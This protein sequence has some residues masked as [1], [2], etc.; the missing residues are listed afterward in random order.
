MISVLAG[1]SSGVEETFEPGPTTIPQASLVEQPSETTPFA[2]DGQV[3]Y[4]ATNEPGA[5]DD[6]N[7]LYPTHRGGRDGPWRTIQH[8]AD[9]LRQGD[10]AHVREGV[11][12]EAGITFAN[13]GEP[14]APIALLNYEGETVVI[15]G[16]E[17]QETLPGI[18][19]VQGR[20]HYV[21]E[22]FTIRNMPWSGIATDEQT[23][24]PYHDITIRNCILYENGWSGIDLAAVDGFL[25]EDV[26]AYSNHFYGMNIAASADGSL[27]SSNGLV[28]NGS[29]HDHTGEEG[30]GLAIN[31]GHDIVVSDS[32]AYHNL[33]HGF[34]VS[35]WPKRGDVSHDIMFERNSSYDNGVSGFSINSNSH[36]VV[37]QNN[38]A[39][40][41]GAEW[42]GKGTATG[43][44]CYGGCWHVEW[45]NNVSVANTAAGFEVENQLGRNADDALLVFRN[46]VT[47]Q[48]GLPEWGDQRPGLVINGDD[49][50]LVATDNNWGGVPGQNVIVVAV[51]VVRNRGDLYTSQD[52]NDGAFQTGNTSLEPQ[53]EEVEAADWR[54]K[55][56]SPL[57]DAG[58]D[59][60][61]P[62]CG[63]A[64]DMGAIESCTP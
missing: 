29:F 54:L 46:N 13:S 7:G 63:D 61:Q 14:G 52:V 8:A 26:E 9:T 40:Q 30:H 59:V 6:N 36:H 27:S 55:A 48:N 17:A 21:I 3:F 4:V 25:V 56:G 58:R 53:F 2:P 1:C 37:F 34:D 23:S 38:A 41:N 35:D 12:F 50:E 19:I 33:I 10:T 44:L 31:Q 45:Y 57:I 24:E 51:N 64:P 42:T 49:W 5:S 60:G 47:Y 43:F 11:Y 22:G 39:W 18:V 28:R 62:F 15:D 16:S 20:G 32:E